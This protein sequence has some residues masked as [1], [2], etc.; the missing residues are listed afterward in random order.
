MQATSISHSE[1]R[2][3][4][5]EAPFSVSGNQNIR[6]HSRIFCPVQLSMAPSSLTPG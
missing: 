3:G 4:R 2:K 1:N 5:R 6:T